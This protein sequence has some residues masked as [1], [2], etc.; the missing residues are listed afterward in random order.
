MQR[1]SCTAAALAAAMTAAPFAGAAISSLSALDGQ[2]SSEARV[3]G[4]VDD[5]ALQQAFS[6]NF[7]DSVASAVASFGSAADSDALLIASMSETLFEASGSAAAEGFADAPF[8]LTADSSSVLVVEIVFDAPG[9]F[10][11]EVSLGASAEGLGSGSA[12]WSLLLGDD[13]IDSESVLVDQGQSGLPPI[14]MAESV[15]L[16][17]AGTYT[18]ILEATASLGEDAAKNDG[19][20]S[21]ARAEWAVSIQI[22]APSGVAAGALAAIPMLGRRRR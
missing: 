2:L 6:G 4:S 7:A 5:D 15:A 8:V 16:S 12:G 21:S 11:F 13:I 17:Q 9:T 22:P 1:T 18:F 14:N 3:G 19:P 10:D 20:R